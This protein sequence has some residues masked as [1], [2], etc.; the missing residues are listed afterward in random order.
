[1]EVVRVSFHTLFI[2][3]NDIDNVAEYCA[4]KHVCYCISRTEQCLCLSLQAVVN[5]PVVA[6]SQ[7]NV[8]VES[9]EFQN[10]MLHVRLHVNI[11][12]TFR[13]VCLSEQF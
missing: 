8:W 9:T 12:R 1:M 3:L 7:M 2:L 10:R 6:L 5:K 13:S 4:I 11:Q